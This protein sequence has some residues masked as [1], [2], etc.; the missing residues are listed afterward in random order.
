MG[1][2]MLPG[3]CTSA[4][5]TALIIVGMSSFGPGTQQKSQGADK[6]DG[7]RPAEEK[8]TGG[9]TTKPLEAVFLARLAAQLRSEKWEECT[10]GLKDVG[11]L[12]AANRNSKTEFVPLLEPLFGLAGWGGIARRNART[13]EDL[14]VRIGAPALPLLRQRL[15][16]A[17]AHDRRV[18][19]E[20]L[21]RIGPADASLVKLL[22]PLLADRDDFVRQAAIEGLGI[23]GPCAREAIDDLLRVATADPIL[24]RRVAARIALIRVAGVSD[25]R[26][27]ALAKFL[28]LKEPCDGAAAFAA[29]AL[30]DLGP[31]A[32]AALP[33][34]RPALR[35]SMPRSE[36]RP[37]PPWDRLT[38]GRRRRSPR[39]S[40]C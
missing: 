6:N 1:T 25:E 36:S 27:Q 24:P 26:V 16:S 2:A 32:K 38:P 11:R 28:E 17:E 29:A 20:L 15:K 34:L 37:L 30:G 21:V 33:A 5:A 9:R 10:A 18:A 23:V 12:L 40:A 19:V 4:F 13:A 31:Q 35:M 8:P 22:R 14:I 3:R 39:C 7:S